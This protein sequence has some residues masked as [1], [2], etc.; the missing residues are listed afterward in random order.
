MAG[1][2]TC[3]NPQCERLA[4]RTTQPAWKKPRT[5]G[6]ADTI[7]EKECEV[8]KAE[9][10]SRARVASGPGDERF[11]APQFAIAPAIF[12]NNDTKYHTNKLRARQFAQRKNKVTL[13][14]VA[15]DT[16]TTDA[17]HSRPSMTTEKV[18]WLQRHDR[19]SG[20]LYG[21]LPL[22][23]G[24]PFALTDH[25]DR[26]PEKQLLRGKIGYLHS[27][28]L[29]DDESSTVVDGE[30]ILDKLP[31]AV[32]LKFPRATW[33]LPCLSEP[34]L[35]PIQPR[36]SMWFLDKGRKHPMLGVH[37]KQLPLAPAFAITAHASQGQTL[38]AA[39]ID[40]MIGRGTSPIAACVALTR[41]RRRRFIGPSTGTSSRRA[42]LK[43]QP[44]CFGCYV[45]KQL[46]GRQ[47]SSSTHHRGCAR[48]ATSCASS[49]AT[50][51]HSGTG[52]TRGISASHV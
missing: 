48:A 42:T 14:A 35:Y 12:P 1:K 25:I 21:M 46:I 3:G 6:E 27:W 23:Q 51:S 16:P 20:D 19:E 30:R 44:C 50:S 15:R 41:V 29:A 2:V 32:F 17:L 18:A 22:I 34:G 24:M 31:L 49:P 39:I 38:L 43:V 36:T 33:R 40:M 11:Q 5:G 28:V 26:N 4:A 9:R 13:Y 52:G 37:R 47:L 7:L 10:K 8:C 45:E